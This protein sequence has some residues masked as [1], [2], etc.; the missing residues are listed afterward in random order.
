MTSSSLD[1][2]AAA[3]IAAFPKLTIAE[4]RISVTL[5]KLLAKGR[6]VTAEHIAAE[7]GMRAGQVRDALRSW[8]GVQFDS[9][10]SVVGYWGLT[11]SNTKHRLRVNG[12]SLYTWC[13]WDTLF[14][15][16]ILDADAEVESTCPVSGEIVALRVTPRGVEPSGNADA[17]V[18]FV[19][20]QKAKIEENL[21]KNFC[22]FVHFFA[23]KE[24]GRK[25][26]SEHPGTLVL[27]IEEAWELGRRKNAA[28]YSRV[29]KSDF[30]ETIQR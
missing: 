1:Q 16:T 18:S 13:A 27:T 10:G 28:Q 30:L 12:Q 9:A 14:I 20:P 17:V 19:A 22:H 21:I 3:I 5:Y 29:L 2:L 26:V 11:L 25:W 6:P 24:N 15:P 4:Q 8:H 23:T 7:A